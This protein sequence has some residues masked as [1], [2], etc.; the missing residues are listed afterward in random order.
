MSARVWIFL[1]VFTQFYVWSVVFF[2]LFLASDGK[3][4]IWV[5]SY[6]RGRGCFVSCSHLTS[7]SSSVK[8]KTDML[9]PV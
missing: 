3:Y 8:V 5:R 7:L 4:F 2:F 1:G 6:S 9:T